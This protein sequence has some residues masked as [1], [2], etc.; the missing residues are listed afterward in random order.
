VAANIA[1]LKGINM[2]NTKYGLLDSL[3]VGVFV[4]MDKDGLV[5]PFKTEEKAKSFIEN[6]NYGKGHISSM[7]W[8]GVKALKA[9]EQFDKEIS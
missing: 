3:E 7:V 5:G 8:T 6:I 1:F 2:Y 4:V 9:L